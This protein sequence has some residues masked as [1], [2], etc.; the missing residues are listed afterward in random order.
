M[1][2]A[3]ELLNEPI[4]IP[5]ISFLY[6]KLTGNELSMLDAVCLVLAIPATFVFKTITDK[7]PRELG[8]SV[9]DWL[10]TDKTLAELKRRRGRGKKSSKEL[11]NTQVFQNIDTFM[12]DMQVIYPILAVGTP[13]A[14]GMWWLYDTWAGAVRSSFDIADLTSTSGYDL[15]GALKTFAGDFLIF[16]L[17]VNGVF[18]FTKTF[19]EQWNDPSKH[20]SFPWVFY[21]WLSGSLPIIA[22]LFGS[23]IGT[24]ATLGTTAFQVLVLAMG[25]SKIAGTEAWTTEVVVEEWLKLIGDIAVGVVPLVKAPTSIVVAKAALATRGA[26]NSMNLSRAIKTLDAVASDDSQKLPKHIQTAMG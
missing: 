3:T 16:A 26:G 15:R 17:S 25:H 11:M 10:S 22:S 7:R 18:D 21:C 1:L 14:G 19:E 20:G 8:G 23:K 2:T 13:L 6:R 24:A 12:N 9:K 5:V 4:S